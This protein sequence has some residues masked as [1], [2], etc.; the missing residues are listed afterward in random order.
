MK[1]YFNLL[2]I[3]ALIVSCTKNAN[4]PVF[5]PTELTRITDFNE[6][7]F[8]Y[9]NGATA[10]AAGKSFVISPISISTL[11]GME[12]NT[13]G[14]NTAYLTYGFGTVKE[15]NEFYNKLIDRYLY[16]RDGITAS[17]A[18]AV[19][20]NTAV[21]SGNT[22]TDALKKYFGA[23]VHS[24]D[25]SKGQETANQVAAWVKD[26]AGDKTDIG[27]LSIDKDASHLFAGTI[28][29]KGE[30][31]SQFK[32]SETAMKPFSISEG[33]EVSLPT[34]KQTIKCYY[35]SSERFESVLLDY[36]QDSRFA[37]RVILPK[38]GST[39]T[40]ADWY[41]LNTI[42]EVTTVSIELPK[43]ETEFTYAP[44]V[45]G[46]ND[47]ACLHTAKITVDEKGGDVAAAVS[48][49]ATKS[50]AVIPVEFIANKP[51]YYVI[52]DAENRLIYFV[53]YYNGK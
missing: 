40:Y 31:K 48:E 4:E 38:S 35:T 27:N 8:N 18:N 42:G 10:S 32:A 1:K 30:W 14:G 3:A 41:A 39:P 9:F 44:Q 19:F 33:N 25:F 26:N 52:T 28:C 7:A 45:S 47:A 36:G 53:G 12:S 6:A 17:F 50:T 11:L 34:M 37:M 49:T 16:K 20:E 46:L 43:F 24:C 51:F 23:S 13:D 21:E 2:F 29:F 15:S 5:K 22:D